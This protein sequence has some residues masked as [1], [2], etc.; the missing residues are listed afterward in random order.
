M[1]TI[2]RA[3]EEYK[4]PISFIDNLSDKLNMADCTGSRE[5]EEEKEEERRSKTMNRLR[6]RGGKK[7]EDDAWMTCDIQLSSCS[8]KG[9]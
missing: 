8:S 7:I 5:E 9:T 1:A 4:D 2:S 3:C 6:E